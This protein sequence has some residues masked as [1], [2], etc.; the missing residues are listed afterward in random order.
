[1]GSDAPFANDVEQVI[2]GSEDQLW[3]AHNT[4]MSYNS[5]I[6]EYETE[7]PG[8]FSVFDLESKTIVAYSDT[9]EHELS[10]SLKA[11]G[12]SDFEID[13]DGNM[14][15]SVIATDTSAGGLIEMIPGLQEIET[16]H[17]ENSDIPDDRPRELVRSLGSMWMAFSDSTERV[18]SFDGSEW[19]SYSSDIPR[20]DPWMCLSCINP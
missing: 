7:N 16:Y 13:Y 20:A 19:A 15:A 2:E 14:W 10:S 1:M 12:V 18:A 9:I 5:D 17:P 4:Q 3:I 8:G 6:G 11:N